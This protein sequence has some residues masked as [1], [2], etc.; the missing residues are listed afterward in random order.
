MAAEKKEGGKKG[1]RRLEAVSTPSI[2]NRSRRKGKRLTDRGVGVGER[3]KWTDSRVR[4]VQP[5]GL[6]D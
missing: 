1:E 6:G 4:G 3:E 2:V 5:V